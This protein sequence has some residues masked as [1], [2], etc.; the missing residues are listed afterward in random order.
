MEYEYTSQNLV[1]LLRMIPMATEEQLVMFF[2]NEIG[3]SQLL[4]VI[5]NLLS[6]H[7]IIRQKQNNQ[8]EVLTAIRPIRFSKRAVEDFIDSF[9]IIANMGAESVRWVT[10]ANGPTRYIWICEDGT[11]TYDVSVIR[12]PEEAR[13]AMLERNAGRVDGE[14]D[15]INHI[16]LCSSKEA[17]EEMKQKLML[18]GFDSY[19]VLD[20]DTHYANYYELE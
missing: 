1:S 16:A 20:P 18:Y 6:S 5:D 7:Y 8:Y 13:I 4:F 15:D 12:T 17:G 10:T 19:C 14:S 3:E 9:W 2:S 11:S